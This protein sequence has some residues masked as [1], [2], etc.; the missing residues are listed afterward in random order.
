[1][2]SALRKA[3]TYPQGNTNIEWTHTDIHASSGFEYT[4]SVLERAAAAAAA[5][6][7]AAAAAV[8]ASNKLSNF[9]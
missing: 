3:S 7:A 8:W 5:P 1:V 6:A 2:G 4:I 9:L